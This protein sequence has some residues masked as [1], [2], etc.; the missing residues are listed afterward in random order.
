[1]WSQ[2][3]KLLLPL[4]TLKILMI[5]YYQQL[6]IQCRERGTMLLCLEILNHR[7]KTLKMFED[8]IQK[9]FKKKKRKKKNRRNLLI[10]KLNLKEMTMDWVKL[11]KIPKIK[12]M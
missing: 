8:K 5:R 1:M 3:L 12:T 7:K 2:K 4:Y 9:I 10:I 11:F 6:L